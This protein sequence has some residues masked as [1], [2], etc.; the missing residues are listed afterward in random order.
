[1]QMRHLGQAV[2]YHVVHRAFGGIAPGDMGDG[3][4]GH[5]GG[6][7]GGE[8]FVTVAENQ[9]QVGRQARIVGAET[10]HAQADGS[11][12][13]HRRVAGQLDVHFGID[14]KAI[15]LDRLPGV[16]VAAAPGAC[17]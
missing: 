17:R 5:G 4:I 13:V 10:G 8:N 15:G 6:L 3:D 2:A 7:R 12:D 14:C 16:A 9:Q 1:M 11:G